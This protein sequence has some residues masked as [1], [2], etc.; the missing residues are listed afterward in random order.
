MISRVEFMPKRST[1][2]NLMSDIAAMVL[3][4]GW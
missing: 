4:R 3:D 2:T 1:A